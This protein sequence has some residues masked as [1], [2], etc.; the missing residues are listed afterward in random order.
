MFAMFICACSPCGVTNLSCYWD[1]L[2]ISGLLLKLSCCW[3]TCSYP[4]QTI[5]LLKWI[6]SEFCGSY[7][8]VNLYICEQKK[9]NYCRIDWITQ[10]NLM[11]SWLKNQNKIE[12]WRLRN[13]RCYKHENIFLKCWAPWHSVTERA[14]PSFVNEFKSNH[15][16]MENLYWTS[17]VVL[18]MVTGKGNKLGLFGEEQLNSL[19]FFTRADSLNWVV[20]YPCK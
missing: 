5:L 19:N 17:L 11:F 13:Y 14:F 6:E 10:Q 12:H 1:G 8:F 7:V 15:T 16:L 9:I 18:Q 4:D 3:L 2:N 20:I